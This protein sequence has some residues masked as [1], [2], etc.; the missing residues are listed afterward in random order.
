MKKLHVVIFILLNSLITAQ[1]KTPLID[2]SKIWSEYQKL[3]TSSPTFYDYYYKLSDSM[4]IDN[5]TYFKVFRFH[6]VHSF[7]PELNDAKDWYYANILI[8]E[9]SSKV[10]TRSPFDSS[11]V[12]LYDFNLEKLDTIFMNSARW[13]VD[14]ID[15]I[16]I[17]NGEYKKRM[18]LTGNYDWSD[19]WIEGVGS[20]YGLL[21]ACF[22]PSKSYPEIPISLLCVSWKNEILYST[23]N[24][25]PQFTGLEKET[26]DELRIYPTMISDRLNIICNDNIIYD[27]IIYNLKGSVVGHK[28]LIGE[29]VIDCSYLSNGVYI[30]SIT[31]NN[32]TISQ[33]VVKF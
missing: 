8:G 13:V 2:K 7:Y 15:S 30:V 24:S 29:Q 28:E 6:T 19:Y 21:N 17:K 5:L 33:R 10:Y 22:N 1:D 16:M 23:C 4:I 14:S 26:R 27:I 12:L 32:F 11:K 18:H 31:S 9:D 20:I 3:Y 25:C